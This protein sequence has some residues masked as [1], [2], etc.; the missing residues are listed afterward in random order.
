MDKDSHPENNAYFRQDLQSNTNPDYDR[1][2]I[3][4]KPNFVIANLAVGGNFPGIYNVSEITA[5]E[6]GPRSMYIDWIRIYQRGDDNQS[7]VCPS[8]SDAIE[9]EQPTEATI[10]LETKDQ[11]KKIMHNGQL[12]IQYG[13]QI[14]TITGQRIK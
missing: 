14:F 9:G 1:S 12:F 5:L 13:E 3:F 8:P 11:V 6:N 7:F 10:V 4:G 2:I